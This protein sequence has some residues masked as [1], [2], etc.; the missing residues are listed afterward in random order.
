MFQLVLDGSQQQELPKPHRHNYQEIIFL[1]KGEACHHIDGEQYD[2]EAPFIILVA[3]GKVHA[4]VP[5]LHSRITVVR[6]TNEFLKDQSDELFSQFVRLSKIP[7]QTVELKEKVTNLLQ[8]I[9]S[10]YKSEKPNQSV[11]RHLLS[12]YISMLKEEKRKLWVDEKSC[13][14][15]N[16][17][18][19]NRFLQLLESNFTTEQSVKYYADKL[20]ITRKKLDEASIQVFDDHPSRI[21]EK[22]LMLEAKRLLMYSNQTVQEIAFSLGFNDHSYFTK[23][24]RKNEGITPSEFREKHSLAA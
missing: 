23:A 21:I 10:E 14:G 9:F 3:Q 12:A 11:L 20:N 13:K 4:F 1:E 7:V 16:Y 6:F 22:R 19:F 8:L 17:D 15:T 5:H 18:I 24:F 2:V